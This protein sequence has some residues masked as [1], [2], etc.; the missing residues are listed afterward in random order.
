MALLFVVPSFDSGKVLH[1]WEALENETR[2]ANHVSSRDDVNR[3]A[4]SMP[5]CAADAL[6]N[7]TKTGALQQTFSSSADVKGSLVA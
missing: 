4:G 3:C 2:A 6:C 1:S 5:S 7:R